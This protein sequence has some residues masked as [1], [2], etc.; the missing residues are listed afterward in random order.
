MT[1]PQPGDLY[2]LKQYEAMG[3]ISQNKEVRDSIIV[4]G[5]DRDKSI[6]IVDHAEYKANLWFTCFVGGSLYRAHKKDLQTKCEKLN[7]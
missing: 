6:L 4:F 2:V 7:K 3:F 1:M 5:S